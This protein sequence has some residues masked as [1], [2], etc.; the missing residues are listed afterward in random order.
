MTLTRRLINP[1]AVIPATVPT[2]ILM[3]AIASSI[4]MP[5]GIRQS[6]NVGRSMTTNIATLSTSDHSKLSS[7]RD[8]APS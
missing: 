8:P 5:S 4:V 6:S 2:L 3:P 1:Y 7:R